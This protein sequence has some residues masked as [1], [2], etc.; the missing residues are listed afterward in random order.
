MCQTS[1]K[2]GARCGGVAACVECLA[3]PVVPLCK[4]WGELRA[5]LRSGDRVLRLAEL[6][7]RKGEVAEV[8]VAFRGRPAGLVV[9]LRRLLVVAR[10]ERSGA[11]HLHLVSGGGGGG[12]GGGGLVVVSGLRSRRLRRRCRCAWW[13]R[14]TTL[15]LQ[16]RNDL[17]QAN[18][19]RTRLSRAGPQCHH[20]AHVLQRLAEALESFMRKSSPH[21]GFCILRH[22]MQHLG[23]V[24]LSQR[25]ILQLTGACRAVVPAF[26]EQ[27]DIV[28]SFGLQPV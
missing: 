3:E 21:Q 19:G 17:T 10:A 9:Q 5:P 28:D 22:S 13:R 14:L 25:V 27:F 15:L 11:T 8:R 24:G 1:T 16:L 4:R 18:A 23:A 7:K 12:G 20:C 2:R 26:G 6:Q